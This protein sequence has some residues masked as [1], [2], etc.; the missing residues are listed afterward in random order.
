MVVN[1]EGDLELYALHDTPKQA[2][3]SARGD[4][5]ISA[6]QTCRILEGFPDTRID[7]EQSDGQQSSQ[8]AYNATPHTSHS[9][10]RDRAESL[11]RDRSKRKGSVIP[12]PTPPFPP[13]FGRGDEDGFPALV[14][15]ITARGPTNLA[16]TRPKKGRGFS[17]SEF[18]NYDLDQRANYVGESRDGAT[19]GGKR[20]KEESNDTAGRGVTRGRRLLKGV[21][22]VVEDD[23]SMVMRRRALKGYGLSKVSNLCIFDSYRV[24][25]SLLAAAKQHIYH[26]R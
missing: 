17:P 2:I 26:P 9:R 1:K 21:D 3:W 15:P 6:G 10:S 23:I 5:A 20:Q 13:F 22:H 4:L 19:S 8:Y 18:K 12:T 7:A 14:S 11:T 24:T 16:A 25:T